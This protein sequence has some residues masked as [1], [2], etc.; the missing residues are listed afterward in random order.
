MKREFFVYCFNM[1]VMNPKFKE[2][3]II[4]ILTSDDEEIVKHLA[5]SVYQKNILNRVGKYVD[6]VK[7]KYKKFK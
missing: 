2:K 5:I 3:D 1:T 6:E 7:I 4:G